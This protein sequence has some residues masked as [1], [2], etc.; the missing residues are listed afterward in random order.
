MRISQIQVRLYQVRFEIL[1]ISLLS[2]FA[3]NL[4]FNTDYYTGVFQ[5]FTL[6]FQFFAGANLFFQRN[7]VFIW[8]VSCLGL[9]TLTI[10]ILNV[11][12]I[13]PYANVISF[14]YLCLFASISYEVFRE[15]YKAEVVNRKIVYAA[16]CGILLLGYCGFFIFSA[17]EYFT[18]G[19]FYGIS[20][21]SDGM[22]DLFYYSFI[23][24]MTV[25]YGDITPI[26]WSAK[27]ATIIVNIVSYVYSLIVVSIIVAQ[28]TSYNRRR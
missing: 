16:V 5:I 3:L 8:I 12:T 7:K 6:A 25:G 19:S 9:L 11:N 21:G 13:I 10:R 1:L 4:F 24:V 15:M 23:S 27:N 22:N 14:F 26:T 2:V 28:F 20:S 17:I 18:P